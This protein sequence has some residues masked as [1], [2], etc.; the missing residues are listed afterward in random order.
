MSLQMYKF[1]LEPICCK[2]ST[3]RRRPPKMEQPYRAASRS[4][5]HA[6][7]IDSDWLKQHAYCSYNTKIRQVRNGGLPNNMH[8][9]SGKPWEG[10]PNWGYDTY[11]HPTT[12]FEGADLLADDAV[13]KKSN[14]HM[15]YKKSGLS[16]AHLLVRES[17]C[18]MLQR[19][20][21]ETLA[22]LTLSRTRR[23]TGHSTI[24]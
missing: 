3:G 5:T 8:Q 12:G 24:P 19:I 23:Q 18:Q 7:I 21:T 13:W 9:L 15:V 6:V 22:G 4:S 10:T 17:M 16:S 1:V 11:R 14:S 20:K 2:N